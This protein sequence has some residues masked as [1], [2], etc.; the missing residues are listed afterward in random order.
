MSPNEFEHLKR[1]IKSRGF[2]GAI[3]SR[4]WQGKQQIIDGEH[5]WRAACELGLKT[6]PCNSEE[7]DD[8][9]AKTLTLL[10]NSI[11]GA[12][13]PQLKAKIL[14]DL[15]T[16]HNVSFE[17]LALNLNMKV[18][19]LKATIDIANLPDYD[20]LTSLPKPASWIAPTAASRS[21][22]TMRRPITARRKRRTK[23]T[24]A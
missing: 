7:M 13:D 6:I 20:G 8:E 19:E 11:K 5:R 14:Q 10:L 9:T 23:T 22:S 1:T 18:D 12:D 4:P 24:V 21:I 3:V 15:V 17:K 2:K 16:V